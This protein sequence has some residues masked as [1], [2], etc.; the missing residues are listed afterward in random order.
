MSGKKIDYGDIRITKEEYPDKMTGL[1][2][3]TWAISNQ[4]LS[5]YWVPDKMTGLVFGNWTHEFCG[6]SFFR[7]DNRGRV[8]P[9]FV[10]SLST[11]YKE[12][13]TGYTHMQIKTDDSGNPILDQFS[14]DGFVDCAFRIVEMSETEA[15]YQLQLA[16]SY[17][18]QVLGMDVEVVKNVQSAFDENSEIINEHVY[19]SGVVFKRRDESSDRL[20]STIAKLYGFEDHELAMCDQLDFSMIA[21]HQGEIDMV[22]FPLR[23]K[24]YLDGDGDE[25]R[26]ET[27]FNLDLKNGYASWNEKDA[28][29]RQALIDGLGQVK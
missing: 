24:I 4:P 17:D 12:E 26:Y 8:T 23:L 3:K 25:Y 6:R 1:V 19:P 16:A 9:K 22:N 28:E 18:D 15:G 7:D 14:K 20:I 21:L 5:Q 11:C 2:F 29:Y 10:Q 27:Y 13:K